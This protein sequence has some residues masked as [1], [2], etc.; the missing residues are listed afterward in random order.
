[1]YTSHSSLRFIFQPFHFGARLAIG[2]PSAN[3]YFVR[4]WFQ[5][6]KSQR[7]CCVLSGGLRR[8]KVGRRRNPQIGRVSLFEVE[9]SDYWNPPFTFSPVSGI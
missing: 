8:P 9:A 3:R 1:M 5:Q 4:R 2:T 6:F 7:H